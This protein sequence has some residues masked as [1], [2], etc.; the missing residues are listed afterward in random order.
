MPGTV[1]DMA[2]VDTAVPACVY[3]VC[4]VPGVLATAASTGPRAKVLFLSVCTVAVA[5]V[6]AGTAIVVVLEDGT[7]L[8]PSVLG[9]IDAVLV[10]CV[11]VTVD[12]CVPVTATGGVAVLGVGTSLVFGVPDTIPCRL[13]CVACTCVCCVSLVPCVPP[14]LLPGIE[15]LGLPGGTGTGRLGA[16]SIGGIHSDISQSSQ[17][18]ITLPVSLQKCHPSWR[19]EQWMHSGFMCTGWSMVCKSRLS[20]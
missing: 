16:A 19:P 17:C 4:P 2:E 5:V 6:E 13:F 1:V 18:L 8:V 12:T 20:W 11:P 9:M 15:T 14:V 3:I 7:V 10:L